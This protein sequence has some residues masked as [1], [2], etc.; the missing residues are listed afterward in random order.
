MGKPI[1]TVLI[2]AGGMSF[3][4]VMA[5][6]VLHTKSLRGSTL[7]LMDIDQ[8][9]LDVARRVAER[10]NRAM[11]NPCRIE[12]SSDLE[13]SV[14]DAQFALISVEERRFKCWD[15]DYHIPQKYGVKH[16]LGENGGPGGVFHALRT[17][18]LVANICKRIEKVN[19]EIFIIN[20]TNPMSPVTL[21]INKA[22]KL[23]NIGLC[24][25]FF[26]GVLALGIMLRLRMS[27]ISAKAH[28]TNHFSWFYEIKDAETGDDLYPKVRRHFRR[29]PFLHMPLVR[30]CLDKYGLLSVTTDDHM[31]EYLTYATE[32]S[33]PAD[34]A[35]WFYRQDCRVRE[36]A[37]SRYA[38]GRLPL[39]ARRIPVSYEE[40]VSVVEALAHGKL[41]QFNAGNFPNKGY[42][43]NIPD[44]VVVEVSYRAENGEIKPDKTPPIHD[45]LADI[46]A[47]RGKLQDMIVEAALEG[48][49]DLA[50]RALCAEPISPRDPDT[51][52]RLFDE[53]YGL[54]RD[55]LPFDK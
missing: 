42:I 45:D 7:A 34:R 10:M 1:K 49:A 39:P 37:C 52:R 50:F 44:G 31:G 46:M 20:L 43:P 55:L 16:I 23:S 47:Q 5:S 38:A 15:Q 29:Y 26:G 9:R 54:Q 17:V 53:L 33:K 6:D 21:G 25:E 30:H 3:G 36:W 24:H 28:G 27:R 41:R 35:R 18:P 14:K 13:D 8:K 48:D 32:I 4:P 19:P 40:A 2:G 12:V 11:G 51:C 22:T